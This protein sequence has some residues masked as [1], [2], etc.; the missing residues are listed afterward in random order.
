MALCCA[1]LGLGIGSMV[2]LRISALQL[3]VDNDLIPIAT[4]ICTSSMSIGANVVV[5]IMGT[6]L[7]NLILAN[8]SEAIELQSAIKIFNGKG[9]NVDVSQ[10]IILLKLLELWKPS[11]NESESLFGVACEQLKYGFNE[12]FKYSFMSQLACVFGIL[13]LVPFIWPKQK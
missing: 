8:T 10:Y 13:A 5:S 1:M 6:I 3:E 12:A 2:Q 11:S 4:G 9:L 7:N